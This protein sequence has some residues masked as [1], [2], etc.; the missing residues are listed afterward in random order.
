MEE[1]F[2]T[3]S[4]FGELLLE[5]LNT[6]DCRDFLWIFFPPSASCICVQFSK[7]ANDKDVLVS[8]YLHSDEVKSGMLLETCASLSV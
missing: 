2:I 6:R 8:K 5:L 4:Y 3:S 7:L 1:C